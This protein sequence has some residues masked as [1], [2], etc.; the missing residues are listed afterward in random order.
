MGKVMKNAPV[1]F[2]IAQIRYN[3]ILS[4]STYIPVIQEHFRKDGF[5]DFKSGVTMT[6]N[7]TPMLQ[8]QNA[9]GQPPAPTRVE[10]YIF[11]NRENTKNFL[12]EQGSLAFQ[13]TEY[14]TFETFARNLLQGLDFLNKT[15]GLSF[16]E[17]IGV[18]YLDAVIPRAGEML[19]QYLIPEVMGLCGKLKGD[20]QHSFSETLTR[21]EDGSLVSRTVI[22][23]GQGGQIGFPPDLMPLLT[24]KVAQRFMQVTGL[25]AI[26][27][28][29][30]FHSE[31]TNFDLA[32]AKRKLTILHDSIT[33]SFRASTTE[34]ARTVWA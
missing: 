24:L 9:E 3:P 1:Y 12:L 28:T 6:L 27:D 13:A 26:I 33:T 5:P 16:I 31:R 8:D 34:H 18:R 2:T 29:D 17:R 23:Q 15:V 19:S 4:L 10:R 32:E 22:Q 7:L 20:V 21:I 30:A 25:H 11:S 14:E